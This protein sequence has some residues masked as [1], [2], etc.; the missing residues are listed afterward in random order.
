MAFNEANY[1]IRRGTVNPNIKSNH[2]RFN[3]VDYP[4]VKPFN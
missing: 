2:M 4:I 3:G 1:H